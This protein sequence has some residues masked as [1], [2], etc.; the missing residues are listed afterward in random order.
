MVVLLVHS[1]RWAHIGSKH[2]LFLCPVIVIRMR[3]RGSARAVRPPD[4]SR[5]DVGPA[6]HSVC[7]VDNHPSV[8]DTPDTDNG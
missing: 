5:T 4:S 2:A 3:V 8:A 7:F 1:A 6:V